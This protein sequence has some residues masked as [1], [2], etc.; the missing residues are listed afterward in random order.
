MSWKVKH[1]LDWVLVNII[2]NK[3]LCLGKNFEKK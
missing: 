2:D 3:H 1:V